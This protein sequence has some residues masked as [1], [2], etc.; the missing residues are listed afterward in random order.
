MRQ[1]RKKKLRSPTEEESTSTE[2]EQPTLTETEQPQQTPVQTPT[3]TPQ[4]TPTQEQKITSTPQPTDSVSNSKFDSNSNSGDQ[5][6]VNENSNSKNKNKSTLNSHQNVENKNNKNSENKN[7]NPGEEDISNTENKNILKSNNKNTSKP[8]L[9]LKEDK[10]EEKN[11]INEKTENPNYTLTPKNSDSSTKDK[12]E[13]ESKPD[14][15]KEDKT[16]EDQ[17]SGNNPE[18]ISSPVDLNTKSKESNLN[19]KN[20]DVPTPNLNDI[21]SRAPVESSDFKDQET[22]NP[23]TENAFNENLNNI[24][25]H[26]ENTDNSNSWD[27]SKEAGNSAPE[28][29]INNAPVPPAQEYFFKLET[30]QA[31][32]NVPPIDKGNRINVEIENSSPYQNSDSKSELN[33]KSGMGSGVS[34]EPASNVA[35]KEL[36]T[37]S[38]ISGYHVKYDFPEGVT[39]IT[40]IEYDAKRTF[41]KTTTS[42]EVL[43]NK[44]TLVKT[45]PSGRVYKHVN[46]WVGEGGAGKSEAL[47]NGVVGFKV[48]KAWIKDNRGNEENITLQ[49]YDKE[50]KILQTQK[51]GED[52]NYVYFKAKTPA[53]SSFAITEYV[54]DREQSPE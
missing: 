40:F 12:D 14:P 27:W 54:N 46:I 22:V 21:N 41:K 32:Q 39:C 23:N 24:I 31:N 28:T 16:G 38:V 42:V 30:I 7:K 13:I 15:I 50:W 4:E 45:L 44:S 35:V 1:I 11:S 47:E 34:Q 29:A 19:S 53:Y 36:S 9:N 17:E 5:D 3:Q 48:E 43:K 18:E 6:E 8:N 37:R 2:T 52:K 25:Q 20:K 49:W 33:S 10:V 26:A 51:T